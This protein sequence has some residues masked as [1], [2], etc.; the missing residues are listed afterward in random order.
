[1]GYK[2]KGV[3]KT[4]AHKACTVFGS[5]TRAREW[6]LINGGGD[7]SL[8][9]AHIVVTGGLVRALLLQGIV[10]ISINQVLP[11]RTSTN[12]AQCGGTLTYTYML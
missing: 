8:R 7:S 5:Q 3:A 10:A 2:G 4:K 9:H 12:T 1:M 6:D 11:A